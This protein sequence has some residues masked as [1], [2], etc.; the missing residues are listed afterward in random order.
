MRNNTAKKNAFEGVNRILYEWSMGDDY[1]KMILEN[2]EEPNGLLEDIFGD[3]VEK[4]E[5]ASIMFYKFAWEYYPELGSNPMIEVLAEYEHDRVFYENY[6]DHTT[7]I[8]KTFF[9]GIYFYDQI[10]FISK[11]MNNVLEKYPDKKSAFL[12]VWTITALYHDMGYLFENEI[13]ENYGDE[14]I[15]FKNKFNEILNSP[16]SYIFGKKGITREKERIFIKANKIFMESI[17][18]IGEVEA[19]GNGNEKIWELLKSG[20]K[21]SGLTNNDSINGI[22]EY[23]EFASKKQTLDGRQGYMDHGICSALLFGKTWYSYSEYVKIILNKKCDIDCIYPIKK[24]EITELCKEQDV[25]E[26][27]VK[28]AV[29]AIALHNI[30]TE[31]W[32][33]EDASSYNIILKDFCLKF[34][35]LPLACLLRLCDELQLWDRIRF[36]SVKNKDEIIS[37]KD[38]NLVVLENKIYLY[39]E[40]D[41]AFTDPKNYKDSKYRKLYEKLI[42]YLD[43]KEIDNI[44]TCGLPSQES[45]KLKSR[46]EKASICEESLDGMEL[47]FC[48]EVFDFN[49]EKIKED[50]K[51]QWLV[52]AV[53]LDEDVHFSSF[54]LRQ[55][56]KKNLPQDLKEFGYNN[57]FAVYEDYNEIYYV[58]QSEC[59]DVANR[60]ICHS[61]KNWN[62]LE[63]I[64]CIIMEKMNV[65]DNVFV[66]LPPENSFH[67]LS[68]T[69]LLE[70]YEKH[71]FA[72][73]DLYIYARIPEV[74]DRGVPTFT[75]FLKN[76]LKEQSEE[77]KE[78]KKLNEVFDIL[79]YPEIIGC[80]GE[81]ILE[82]CELIS[83]INETS[84]EEEKQ[85]WK[86]SNGRFLIRMRP[87]VA[88]R[89]EEFT[90]KWK[91]WGYHG[92]RGR[93]LKDF[94]YFAE[95]V[96]L[97]LSNKELKEQEAILIRRQ[98]QAS[99]QRFRM[100]AK[101][102]IDEK[103]QSLFYAYSR[104]GTIKIRRRYCQLKNFYYLDQL[105]FEIAK[106][107]KISEGVVRCMLPNEII[108][109][110]KGDSTVLSEAKAREKARM[111]VYHL[112]DDKEEIIYGTEADN[113]VK[114]VRESTYFGK[115]EDGELFGE[116]ASLGTYKGLCRVLNKKD[117][118]YFERGEILVATDIDPDKFELLQLAGAVITETGGFT[119]HAA[120]VCRELQIPCIVGI[121]DLTSQ[122]HTGQYL[123]IDAGKGRVRIIS[124]EISEIIQPNNFEE[125]NISRSEIGGKAY[126]L[127]QL[128]KAG[129][130]VPDFFCI[131]IS[132]LK[133]AL[134]G[135]K[136]YNEQSKN[137]LIADIQNALNEMNNDWWAIRSSTNRE[138]G[139]MVSGAGQEVTMLR[140]N[141][142]D[143]IQELSQII[144]GLK[145]YTGDGSIIIQKM[146]MGS[147]SG[148][149]F[150]DNPIG[151]SNELII[152]AVPGGCEY[153]TSGQVNPTKYVYQKNLL[154]FD[155]VKVEIWKNLLSE[156]LKEEL[157]KQAIEIEAFF[158]APQDIEWTIQGEHIYILQSRKITSGCLGE[159]ISIFSA[160]RSLTVDTLSIYQAYALPIHLRDHMLRTAAIVCWIMDHWKGKKL[161]EKVMIKACLLHDIGNIVKG[162][163]ETFRVIFPDVFSEDCWQYWLNVRK[164]IGE[165][166]GKTDIEATL[167]IAKEINVEEEVL[168]LIEAKQF[169][170]NKESY[171]SR[172]F[173]R[174]ICAYADQRVSPNGVLS[175]VGRL[176]EA[177]TRHRGVSGSSVNSPRYESLKEYA[178]KIERQIFELVDGHPEDINDKSIEKYIPGLKMYEF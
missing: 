32:N 156:D 28:L 64:R 171:D 13:I 79:T 152:E 166:Y 48:T 115:V 90:S 177:R 29:N 83:F 9:L 60:V 75:T 54:Y 121:H 58:P 72:H 77:L 11:S 2:C 20:G 157:R 133:K 81:N 85:E 65:L 1:V 27:L 100:F 107:H 118:K 123:D 112:K 116:T 4:R 86:S 98:E 45:S 96:R 84:T 52:G 125:I 38:F 88:E 162:T 95:K 117:D 148:V 154:Q 40:S 17:D 89:I 165:K 158:G 3:N 66:D 119:C 16:L 101:Y 53:N 18:S 68:K 5:R 73:R 126:S 137:S 71:Y 43:Q 129:F 34:S 144:K 37:G 69:Q 62:F 6:R 146:I 135:E 97:E 113:E 169:S 22:H 63:N 168:N 142:M 19:E 76:Y 93:A 12:K 172:D 173:E 110:L 99:S 128:K 59:V 170:K 30:N 102:D 104:M 105:L 92:Y 42:I 174:K 106:R 41:N 132:A 108:C 145:D 33:V 167:N 82:I 50:G 178:C 134:I 46:V 39:F 163:D 70:Y 176:D 120:I 35:T 36:R 138:D 74:L 114:K 91:F 139:D 143:I 151:N 21:V 8:V 94:S 51:E 175:L 67:S 161:N 150:T 130:S 44:L 141:K 111:F 26:E 109:L 140:V 24:D 159:Q 56:M 10:E 131:R 122:I 7:H 149:I 15:M 103:Y 49:E 61:L 87:E 160:K 55:S 47:E 155:E 23:Y 164:H 80:S 57:I 147:Y 153:L 31:I 127:I 78:E 25:M 124:S 14:W 136:T